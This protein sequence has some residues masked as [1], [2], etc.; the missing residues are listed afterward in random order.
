YRAKIFKHSSSTSTSM[1]SITLS[2][3]MILLAND[4]SRLIKAAIA[5]AIASSTSVP[6]YRIF[7]LRISVWRWMCLVM[8]RIRATNY[9]ELSQEILALPKP[10]GHV[11]LGFLEH[12]F[13]EEITSGTVF[14]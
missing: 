6:T 2:A 14:D 13:G 3:S 1:R 9:C 5:L 10:P 11:I 8:L 12:R 4:A 7:C